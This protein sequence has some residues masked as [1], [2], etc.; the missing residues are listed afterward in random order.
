MGK[1]GKG[2]SSRWGGWGVTS[3]CTD[4]PLASIFT[5][6]RMWGFSGFKL[7]LVLCFWLIFLLFE[8]NRSQENHSHVKMSKNN[9]FVNF[10][11]RMLK[12]PSVKLSSVLLMHVL[13]HTSSSGQT[14]RTALRNSFV[15]SKTITQFGRQ[16]WF[17]RD[18]LGRRKR[19]RMKKRCKWDRKQEKW[20]REEGGKDRNS[21]TLYL[22]LNVSTSSS[23][24][25][26]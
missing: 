7:Y 13:S 21:K 15:P 12:Y 11:F 16:S 20:R 8:L 26:L 22:Y 4:I 23:C 2:W 3:C 6:L 18:K 5:W 9:A 1:C 14:S 17:S 10:L 25:A 24:F 19:Q